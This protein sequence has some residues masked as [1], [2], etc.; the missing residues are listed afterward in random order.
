MEDAIQERLLHEVPRLEQFL[1]GL[2]VLAVVAP[3]VGLLGPVTGIIQTFAVIRE[4]TTNDPQLLSGGISQALL[5][6]A[7]GLAIAIPALL[8][9]GCFRGRVDRIVSDT[10]RCAASVLVEF[11]KENVAEEAP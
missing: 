11:G 7:G 2:G 6:T 10:E 9:Q 3:L 4:L 8:V 1:G 5:T